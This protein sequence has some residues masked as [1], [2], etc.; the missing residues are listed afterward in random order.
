MF[1]TV[2]SSFLTFSQELSETGPRAGG[3]RPTVKRVSLGVPKC[4]NLTVLRSE[5]NV[6]KEAPRLG[7]TLCTACWSTGLG[8]DPQVT[9]R[10]N[11][12]GTR[13]SSSELLCPPSHPPPSFGTR[14]PFMPA[15]R[16]T[17]VFK[18]A[19][20]HPTV[21]KPARGHPTVFKPA[22][23]ARCTREAGQGG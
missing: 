8:S 16:I 7:Y 18:P 5:L 2:L 11:S 6:G 14:D 4:R 22:R 12:V 9:R 21:F 1:R 17:S 15:G 23:E 20:G 19:R 13:S 3:S 10:V